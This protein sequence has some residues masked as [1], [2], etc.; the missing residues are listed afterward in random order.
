MERLVAVGQVKRTEVNRF[1]RGLLTLDSVLNDEVLQTHIYRLLF[2]LASWLIACS[3][4]GTSHASLAIPVLVQNILTLK[5]VFIQTCYCRHRI[6]SSSFSW[7]FPD[8][9][10]NR[11]N[12]H[13]KAYCHSCLFACCCF[14]WGIEDSPC[15]DCHSLVHVRATAKGEM[16]LPSTDQ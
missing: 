14:I 10:D 12:K 15:M 16:I 13:M 8:Y 2:P 7:F 3:L 4:S 6:F 5:P 9:K 1:Q 11:D